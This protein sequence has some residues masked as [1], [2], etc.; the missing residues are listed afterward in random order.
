MPVAA[1]DSKGAPTARVEPSA[2]SAMVVPKL[3]RRLVLDALRYAC[4]LTVQSFLQPSKPTALPSSH[5]SPAVTTPSPQVVMV[6][7]TSPSSRTHIDCTLVAVW[8]T[9]QI[10]PSG[11]RSSP[12]DRSGFGDWPAPACTATAT[13]SPVITASLLWGLM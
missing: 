3:A 1:L 7:A 2:D 11:H 4:R 6:P 8:V 5:T 9:L 10:S 12:H 13:R